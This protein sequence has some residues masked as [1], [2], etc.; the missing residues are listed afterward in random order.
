MAPSQR[1]MI[2]DRHVALTPG[3]FVLVLMANL[4]TGALAGWEHKDAPAGVSEDAVAARNAPEQLPTE[5]VM[6]RRLSFTYADCFPASAEA[7]VKGVGK[8]LMRHIGTG[9]QVLVRTSLDGS[10]YEPVLG[11]LHM[12]HEQPAIFR[13]ISHKHGSF[14]ASA[15]HLVFVLG[16]DQSLISKAVGNIAVGDVLEYFNND[17]GDR[18]R[19]EILAVSAYA[20]D[21]VYAP[22]TASGVIVVDGVAASNYATL[23][24]NMPVGHGA[25]HSSAFFLRVAFLFNWACSLSAFPAATLFPL[26]VFILHAALQ[27]KGTSS[28]LY[29]H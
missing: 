5:E 21:G 18:V 12:A 23:S 1:K 17:T 26:C 22:V 15:G 28:F 4:L 2:A 8:T 16:Q 7:V 29:S 9:D 24:G 19:S 3:H 27:K 14:D 11:Y 6:A 13:R 20:A 10:A 25:M